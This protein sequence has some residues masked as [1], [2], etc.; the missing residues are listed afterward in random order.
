MEHWRFYC[1]WVIVC[2]CASFSHFSLLISFAVVLHLFP[3]KS[4]NHTEISNRQK[5]KIILSNRNDMNCIS[6]SCALFFSVL[7][8]LRLLLTFQFFFLRSAP[9]LHAVTLQIKLITSTA[10]IGF[11]SSNL[12][13]QGFSN[14][15]RNVPLILFIC[16]GEIEISSIYLTHMLAYTRT[17]IHAYTCV[18]DINIICRICE[19]NI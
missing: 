9:P 10:F 15:I 12:F 18:C 16:C 13:Y 4:I 3:S 2:A 8:P 11:N 5:W 1:C 6:L 14:G 7:F 17:R 19:Y